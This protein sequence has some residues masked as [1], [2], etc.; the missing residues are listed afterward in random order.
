MSSKLSINLNDLNFIHTNN[1]HSYFKFIINKNDSQNYIK[2]N[3]PIFISLY[4]QNENKFNE[5][6]C[7]LCFL[8]TFFSFFYINKSENKLFLKLFENY[9]KLYSL[10]EIINKSFT[11]LF[12]TKKYFF[13]N[14]IF[15]ENEIKDLFYSLSN[16]YNNNSKNII[17][18]IVF[19]FEKENNEDNIIEFNF[20]YLFLK[21]HILLN[22]KN[23]ILGIFNFFE[24]NK[25]NI[26]V[27]FINKNKKKYFVNFTKLIVQIFDSILFFLKTDNNK[28]KDENIN[29]IKILEMNTNDILNELNNYF[30]I[31]IKVIEVIID[32]KFYYF[33]VF[34]KKYIYMILEDIKRF[35]ILYNLKK[36][37]I[38]NSNLFKFLNNIINFCEYTKDDNFIYDIISNIYEI[39]RMCDDIKTSEIFYNKLNNISINKKIEEKNLISFKI[40]NLN[41]FFSNKNLIENENIISTKIS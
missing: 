19:N 37:F 29:N 38:S 18:N 8:F 24:K 17:S 7:D 35:F 40:F 31:S 2:L 33:S 34:I 21:S 30:K 9:I 10:N 12:L 6:K 39:Y 3:L 4:N 28:N 13:E 5:E 36:I 22:N 25:N 26:Q 15:S 41:K 27:F 20:L 11:V 1:L 32:Q 23:Q 16:E 14:I